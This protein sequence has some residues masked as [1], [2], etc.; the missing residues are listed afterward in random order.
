M[1]T[2]VLKDIRRLFDKYAVLCT[3]HDT[4][5]KSTMKIFFKFCGLL[6][7]TQT[8]QCMTTSISVIPYF[9]LNTPSLLKVD[10]FWKDPY[11][12]KKFP[13]FLKGQLISKG[14]FAFFNST[15]K[16]TKNFCPRRLVQVCFVGE[17][18]TPKRHFENNWP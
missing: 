13:I 1:T 12:P 17:L 6:K 16:Q 7:K 11:I 14:C 9:V 18:E 5:V 3:E 15:K 10:V 8:L 2:F 4:L